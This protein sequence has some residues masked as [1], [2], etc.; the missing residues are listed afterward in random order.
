MMTSEI[1]EFLFAIK[2]PFFLKI[3]QEALYIKVAQSL[4]L[5]LNY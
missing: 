5:A 4:M 1:L 3:F 2:A